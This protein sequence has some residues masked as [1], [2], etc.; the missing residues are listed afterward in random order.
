MTLT[1]L[2]KRFALV[3]ALV[4]VAGPARAGVILTATEVGSDVVF[5]GGGTIDL[6]DLTFNADSFSSPGIRPNFVVVLL[7]SLPN[8]PIDYY[9]VITGPAHIGPGIGLGIGS[10]TSGSGDRIGLSSNILIL[11][12]GYTSGSPLSA[13]DTF[14]GQSFASL[15]MTPGTYVWTWGSGASA[16]SLTIQVGAVPEPSS[17]VM[18]GTAIVAAAY[19]RRTRAN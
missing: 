8:E 3:A 6:T 17:L 10:P 14:A 7:G 4:L 19:R 5:Q 1:M 15:G 9:Q 18:L 13:T 11:P 2:T 12:D 16:D